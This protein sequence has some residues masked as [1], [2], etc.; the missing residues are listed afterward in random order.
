MNFNPEGK[1]LHRYIS[2]GRLSSYI[3]FLSILQLG[4]QACDIAV[5]LTINRRGVFNPLVQQ[6]PIVLPQV[7]AQTSH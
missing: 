4:K 5:I 3:K 1:K 2:M 7:Y 6:S